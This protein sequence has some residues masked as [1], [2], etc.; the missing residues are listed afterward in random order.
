VCNNGLL[1][2]RLKTKRL[3]SY[4]FID[5]FIFA[6]FWKGI[7]RNLMLKI[8]PTTFRPKWIFIKSIPGVRDPLVALDTS[9][10]GGQTEVA[11][12]AKLDPVVGLDVVGVLHVRVAVEGLK[13]SF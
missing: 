1:R 9:G 12:G 11:D 13:W 10:G 3:S 4:K 5:K 6:V 8:C 7:F 2:K